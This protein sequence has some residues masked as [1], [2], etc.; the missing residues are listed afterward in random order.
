MSRQPIRTFQLHVTRKCNLACVHCYSS[1]GPQFRETL[2]LADLCDA[3]GDAKELGYG[4]VSLS[5]GEPFLYPDMV[6]LL[7][8]AKALGMKTGTV[9]NG[10]FLDG[11]RLAEL[12]D[13]LDLVVISLDGA[14]ERHNRMR[15]NPRAFEVMAG[16]IGNLRAAGIPF[17]FL[18]TL[19]KENAHELVWAAEFATQEGARALQIHPLDEIGRGADPD[20]AGQVPPEATGV[21]ASQLARFVQERFGGRLFVTID[22]QMKDGSCSGASFDPGGRFCDLVTTL[23]IE[24]DGWVVPMGYGFDRAFALGRLGERPLGVMAE[25]W[26]ADGCRDAFAALLAQTKAAAAHK[27]APL[28]TNMAS[29]LRKLV[30]GTR[31]RRRLSKKRQNSFRRAA[32]S[33]ALWGK[34]NRAFDQARMRGH[35]GDEVGGRRIRR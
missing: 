31:L 19:S 9:T 16:K 17:G 8:H 33:G 22:Y 12:K 18:F 4:A 35:G 10:M 2:S 7:A 13:V 32:D 25:D 34:D 30:A 28:L 15:A 14:P 24:P 26:I 6:P 20:V 3:I 27:D 21:L 5:G 11:R 23:T 29:D 1:S